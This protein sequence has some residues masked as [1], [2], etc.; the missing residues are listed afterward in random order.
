MK[1]KI[2]EYCQGENTI[3]LEGFDD[4]IIGVYDF[5]VIYSATKIIHSLMEEMSYEDSIDYFYYNIHDVYFGD[6]SPIICDDIFNFTPLLS[7][8]EECK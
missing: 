1:D 8:E 2:I 7:Y 5:K 4:C 3:F 6:N